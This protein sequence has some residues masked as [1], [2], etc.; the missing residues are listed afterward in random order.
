LGAFP[1]GGFPGGIHA[2]GGI[3]GG[4]WHG[5]LPG[6]GGGRLGGIGHPFPGPLPGAIHSGGLPGGFYGGLPGHGAGWAGGLPGHGIGWHGGIPGAGGYW[7]HAHPYSWYNGHWHNHWYGNG[8]GG[9]WGGWGY[10][11]GWGLAGWGLGSLWYTSGYMPYYN[12]YYAPLPGVAGAWN[13]SQPIPAGG[14]PTAGGVDADAVNPN[15]AGPDVAGNPDV[16]SAVERFRAGDYAGAL[17][18]VDG[19]IRAQPSD[20]AAHELR[21]LILF[22][23]EDYS[24]AAATIHSV[25]A[26]G[27]GW[28][29]TTLSSLYPDTEIYMTQLRKLEAFVNG[30]PGEADARFLLAYHYMTQGHAGDAASQLEK[31]VDLMPND[32]LAANLLRMVQGGKAAAPPP[33]AVPPPTAPDATPVDP[34][35]LAGDWQASRDD[36]SKFDLNLAADKTFTWK[37]SHDQQSQM[38]A[39]TYSVDNGLLVMQSKTGGAMVGQLSAAAG[40]RFTFKPLGGPPDDPGLT[41][42]R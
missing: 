40:D 16:D 39:G 29:W 38:I 11:L 14:Y 37:F 32:K 35:L 26:T 30:H 34:A 41:F 17:T 5:G 3:A 23:M 6:V 15:L 28:D 19:A 22:A 12:P 25:L 1:G 31:V 13:Y 2:G 21:A 27:P 8:F 9:Y 24:Q 7:Q 10:P 33:D 4:G 36:G 20:A 18:L 42:T